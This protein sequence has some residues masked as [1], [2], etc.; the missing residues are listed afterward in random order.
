[1]GKPRRP[2]FRESR[3]QAQSRTRLLLLGLAMVILLLLVLFNLAVWGVISLASPYFPAPGLAHLRDWMLPWGLLLSGALLATIA[4]GSYQRSREISRG[5]QWL[6]AQ[7]GARPVNPDS[8]DLQERRLINVTEEMAIAAGCRVP[9]LYLLEQEAGIN[10]MVLGHGGNR[11]ALVVTAGALR[12]LPRDALQGLVAHEI[13]HIVSQDARLNMQLLGLLGGLHY[14]Y[15]LGRQYLGTTPSRAQ[16]WWIFQSRSRQR[17][18]PVIGALLCACGWLGTNL[19]RLL[20]AAVCR[21]REWHADAEASRYTRQPRALGEALARIRT[22]EAGS[23]LQSALAHELNPLC[24]AEAVNSTNW[25]A[26]HPP[27][28]ARMQRLGVHKHW[29][30]PPLPPADPPA[31]TLHARLTAAH[32]I[33]TLCPVS[34]AAKLRTLF[35]A[36]ASGTTLILDSEPAHTRF[37]LL[38]LLLLRAERLP[39][40]SRRQLLDDLNRMLPEKA[41]LPAFCYQSLVCHHLQDESNSTSASIKGFDRV[42]ASLSLCLSL[43]CRLGAGGQAQTLFAQL[44]KD[45]F[46]LEQLTFQPR[47]NA[48]ALSRAFAQLRGLS[49]WLKEPVMEAF[50]AAI[51][52]DGRI[53]VEEYELLRIAGLQLGMP[54]A[55]QA[56]VVLESP[57]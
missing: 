44:E 11:E 29:K 45:W 49:S 54:V 42:R 8:M 39:A 28:L 36:T 2:D 16:G 38:E 52:H 7:A 23:H 47:V 53:S 46:P 48:Q 34:A 41:S 56:D 27:L 17:S 51:E 21:Q 22:H 6:A 31:D 18:Q 19:A 35:A 55:M 43:F 25:L 40:V 32:A 30:P 24:I 14:L 15:S 3:A 9:P 20:S 26:T 37:A 5:G 50:T 13:S 4:W 1:M 10:A 12:A 33:D 57:I